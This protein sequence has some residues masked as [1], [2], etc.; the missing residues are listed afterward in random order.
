[1]N[2]FAEGKLEIIIYKILENKKDCLNNVG[3]LFTSLEY[4]VD[5]TA[6]TMNRAPYKRYS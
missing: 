6:F 2:K 1:M 3:K 5:T 4:Y